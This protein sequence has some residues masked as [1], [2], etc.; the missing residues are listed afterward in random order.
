M[1]QFLPTGGFHE[2]ELTK[3]NGKNVSKKI[4]RTPDKIKGGFFLEYNLEQPSNIQG[5]N[6]FHFFQ[7]KKQ[8]K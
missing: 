3:K 4:V 1:S 6:V 7:T 8:L 2:I 5:K